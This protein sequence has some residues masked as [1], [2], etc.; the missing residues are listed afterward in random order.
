MVIVRCALGE[1]VGLVTTARTLFAVPE[2]LGALDMAA[3]SEAARAATLAQNRAGATRL[4]AA[5][6]LVEQFARAAQEQDEQCPEGS[7]RPGYARLAPAARARDHLVAACQLTCWHA[8]RLVTAG[9]QI[10]T[11]LSRLCSVVERGV[12]PEELA[13]DLACRLAGVPDAIVGDVEDEVLAR[14]VEDLEGGDRPSRPA[15]NSAID[16]AVERFDPAGAQ[17][18]AEAAAESR[19]VRFRGARDGMATMWA[20]LTAADAELLRRR[21]ETDAAVAA[22]D[23][24]D[25]PIDQLRADA[26]AALAVYP[27]DAAAGD[28][29]ATATGTGTGTDAAASA[30]AECGIELGQVRAG[31][32]LPRPSLGNAANAGQAIRISVIASA[33][34]GLPNRVEFVHGTY[35][36]FEW[37]C[38]E[39][40]EGDEASVRFELI[41][42]APGVLDSPEHALRYLITPAMAERIRLR[43]GTCRHPGC[44]VPAKDCDVDHVIAFNKRDPELGGPTLEWNLVCLCRKHHREKTFGTNS[45]R[46]GPLGELIIRTDTGHEHRTRPKGPLARARDAIAEREWEAFADRII[47]PDGLLTNPPGQSR[48]GPHTR[49][50]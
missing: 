43:D 41:D 38:T 7:R 1:G 9:V 22:A 50:A 45:Y 13:V 36:S 46:T 16:E 3:V 47:G 4:E 30:A 35:S 28:T 8:E 21:I 19:E 37:L 17:E 31:A 24:L 6:V 33:V 10:H 48:H 14:F 15:V 34:R 5:Y 23:G 44:S 12:I 39:L 42:P 27:P 32:D 11:R 20:K 2:G 25:R 40:L 18:A 29:T 26:L 49:P